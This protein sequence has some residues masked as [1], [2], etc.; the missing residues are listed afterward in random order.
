[1]PTMNAKSHIL[2]I[3]RELRMFFQIP[4]FISQ[5]IEYS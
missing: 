1:M 4:L 3:E 5:D 2:I